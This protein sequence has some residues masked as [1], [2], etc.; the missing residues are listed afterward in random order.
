MESASQR[1][2]RIVSAV[3]GLEEELKEHHMQLDNNA[4]RRVELRSTLA[5]LDRQLIDASTEV[6]AGS[7]QLR[8]VEALRGRA[9]EEEARWRTEQSA[10]AAELERLKVK[11]AGLTQRTST[12][13]S[14]IAREE[15]REASLREQVSII[16]KASHHERGDLCALAKTRRELQ[17]A[18]Q[19]ARVLKREEAIS[20]RALQRAVRAVE[21][22]QEEAKAR[23]AKQARVEERLQAQREELS[24][25]KAVVSDAADNKS[26][27]IRQRK[28]ILAQLRELDRCDDAYRADATEVECILRDLFASAKK[29]R[30]A[31]SSLQRHGKTIWPWSK[32]W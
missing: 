12:F 9:C 23:A 6:E 14:K 1:A 21:Q 5:E 32:I 11:V 8:A 16:S 17:E 10:K 24:E 25:R 28:D 13:L 18:R 29:A 15:T 4:E 30:S 27:I 26:E 22:G 19:E 2:A 7:V 20:S 3:V 31:A